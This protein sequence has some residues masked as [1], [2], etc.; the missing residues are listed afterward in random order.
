[1]KHPASTALAALLFG[2][3]PIVNCLGAESPRHH[4]SRPLAQPGETFVFSVDQPPTAKPQT[5]THRVAEAGDYQLGMAWVEVL[6]GGEVEV[7]IMAGGKL[8]RSVT[9]RPGLSPQRLDARM[10]KLAAGDEITVTATPKAATY[11]LGYQ[12]AF[13]TPTFPGAKIFPRNDQEDRY[14]GD[15]DRH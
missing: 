13:G 5:W 1:M 12:V 9:A 11:R 7:T 8:V 4:F 3:A 2:I 15:D 6:S 10:E 14:R